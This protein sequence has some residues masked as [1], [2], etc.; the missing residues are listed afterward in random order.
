M[1]PGHVA[2]VGGGIIGLATAYHL[3]K[4]GAQVTVIDR[5]P[6]GDRAS[7]G[8]AGGIAVTEV[9][10]ASA[11]G[12]WWRAF[13]WM[14]D[15]LGPVAIRPAHAPELIPWLVRFARSGRAT[16]VERISRA[17][18]ALN[19][20]VYDDLLP[21]LADIGLLSHLHRTG[22]LY[23]YESEAGYRRDALE[24]ACKRSRGVQTDDLT[25][26][27]AREMEPA[28]GRIVHR[29][30]FTPQ[31]S[32]VSDPKIIVLSLRR[33]LRRHGVWLR[34]AEVQRLS[35][36]SA[37]CVTLHSAAG[38]ALLADRAVIAGGAWSGTLAQSL[39]DRVLLESERGYN[40][41]LS[42]PAVAVQR[43]LIFAEHKFVATP[44][45]CGL[46]IGGAA[47]FGGLNA[48][49]NFKRSLALAELASRYLPSLDTHEGTVWAGHR[50]ATPDSLPVIGRSSADS[51]IVYAF[52][53]GHLG[54]TQ[55]ATTG[56][57]VSDLIGDRRPAVDLTP[58]SIDRFRSVN[59][60]PLPV[61]AR[62]SIGIE[63]GGE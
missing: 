46:R 56:R 36:S 14:W 26:D 16:E 40:I 2:V 13:R 42:A 15:P 11:P 24:W 48:R 45:S 52:G 29:A 23:V 38:E 57:L 22:A 62:P 8:N 34:R 12:I 61:P 5:D 49:P 17:L 47:E 55:A 35:G 25:A 27:E 63:I 60:R 58:Y 37:S 7:M 1:S 3:V 21:M 53:H 43:Q 19:N 10:P 51:R 4:S 59:G 33:W 30:I 20:R 39:G 9:F 18:A 41:T 32:H 50:P 31:W 54:L 28:L 6:D 44:L